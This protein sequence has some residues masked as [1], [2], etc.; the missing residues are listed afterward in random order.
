MNTIALRRAQLEWKQLASLRFL[1]G[2]KLKDVGSF[3]GLTVV[4]VVGPDVA[5]RMLL[6]QSRTQE[7]I[8]AVQSSSNELRFYHRPC[9]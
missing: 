6:Q 9:R 2:G 7:Q 1:L 5:A 4:C 8:L 3:F